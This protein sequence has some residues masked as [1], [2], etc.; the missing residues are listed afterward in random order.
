MH[1]EEFGCDDLFSILIGNVSGNV[2][3]LSDG[4]FTHKIRTEKVS[5]I[6]IFKETTYQKC[7]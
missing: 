7:W 3:L 4:F 6:H 5:S 1:P 2:T